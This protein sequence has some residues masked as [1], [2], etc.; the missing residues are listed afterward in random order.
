MKI[1]NLNLY[2]L[3]PKIYINEHICCSEFFISVN[4]F[5]IVFCYGNVCKNEFKT[6]EKQKLTEIK[7]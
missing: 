4:F 5:S 3:T 2:K 7:N 6:K 1:V